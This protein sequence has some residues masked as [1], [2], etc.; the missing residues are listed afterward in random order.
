MQSTII[1]IFVGL[2]LVVSKVTVLLVPSIHVMAKIQ[3]IFFFE[4]RGGI[5]VHLSYIGFN[6]FD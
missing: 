6:I 1:N 4:G 3:P 2:S 5:R